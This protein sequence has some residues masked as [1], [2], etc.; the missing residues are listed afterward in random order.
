MGIGDQERRMLASQKTGGVKRFHGVALAAD[1][2]ILADVDERGN[3][4]IPRSECA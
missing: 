1:F 2:Q 4:R 3:L